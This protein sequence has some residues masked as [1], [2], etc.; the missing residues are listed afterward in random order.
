MSSKQVLINLQLL[1]LPPQKEGEASEKLARAM[2]VDFDNLQSDG[3]STSRYNFFKS[4]GEFGLISKFKKIPGYYNIS[5]RISPGKNLKPTVKYKDSEFV[6]DFSFP[7]LSGLDDSCYLLVFMQEYLNVGEDKKD[8]LLCY[9]I[10]PFNLLSE[11]DQKGY[12]LFKFS[13]MDEDYH[14]YKGILKPSNY[15]QLEFFISLVG[16]KNSLSLE[17]CK[18]IKEYNKK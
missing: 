15:Y 11:P 3:F 13:F 6:S 8:M 9:F 7:D 17:S 2:F 5:T 4:R 1:D 14:K 12:E 16:G 18:F 10:S